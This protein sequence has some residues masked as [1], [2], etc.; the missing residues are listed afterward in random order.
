MA[1]TYDFTN[2]ARTERKRLRAMLDTFFAGLGQGFNAY[3]HSRSRMDQIERLNAL[4]DQELAERGLARED[5][6]RHVF[7]DIFY[8]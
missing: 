2:T 7:R 6:P 3:L 4:S 5:I 8:L 1:Q